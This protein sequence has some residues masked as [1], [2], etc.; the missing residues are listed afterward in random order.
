MYTLF[1]VLQCVLKR[2]LALMV[3]LQLPLS[4][5]FG[6]LVDCF[7]DLLNVVQ[8]E[9]LAGALFWLGV[10]AGCTALGI[11][12][13]VGMD[14]APNPPDGMVQTL[15]QVL[16]KEFGL[17]KNCFDLTIVALAALGGLCFAHALVGI[18][19]GTVINALLVGRLASL[20]R[21]GLGGGME[22]IKKNSG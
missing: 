17:T 3:V 22:N 20:F 8:P 9:S 16:G 6:L 13:V 10:A 4:Y 19:A 21:E 14:L 11:V 1:V 2:R 5:G 15:S 7:D 18:G 12:L